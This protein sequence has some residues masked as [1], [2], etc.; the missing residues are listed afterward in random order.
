VARGWPSAC[1][2]H[3]ARWRRSD[4]IASG[5]A[6]GFVED[7]LRAEVLPLY[8]NTHTTTSATGLQTTCFRHEAR[9]IIK[10]ACNAGE[11]DSLIFVGSGSTS[12]IVK[13]RDALGLQQY[14]TGARRPVVFVGPFEH[15]SNLLP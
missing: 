10:Q 11:D 13:L 15:H 7:Y 5:R 4:Y 9:Q 14:G 12:A 6:V 2:S 8:G 1:R 3:S